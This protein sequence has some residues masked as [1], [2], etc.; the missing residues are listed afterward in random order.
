[1]GEEGRR[2]V[3]RLSENLVM[4]EDSALSKSRKRKLVNIYPEKLFW[5]SV[6]IAGPAKYS[7]FLYQII[8]DGRK[9]SRLDFIGFQVMYAD[10]FPSRAEISRLAKKLER[11]DSAA[12][13]NLAKAMEKD[14]M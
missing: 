9:S 4:L 8:E 11:E 3:A 10:S 14:L 12:W 7:Q 2:K 5:S 13:K 1:M 6:H